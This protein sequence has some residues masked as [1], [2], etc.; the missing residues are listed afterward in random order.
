M[1][2]SF[3]ARYSVKTPVTM[4]ASFPASDDLPSIFNNIKYRRGCSLVVF[5]ESPMNNLTWGAM[6]LSDDNVPMTRPPVAASNPNR[7]Q[8]VSSA[9]ALVR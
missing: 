5:V 3:S 4:I 1:W 9:D 2:A 8:H 7:S 6:T